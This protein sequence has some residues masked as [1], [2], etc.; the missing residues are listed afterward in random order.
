M[1]KLLEERF[2]RKYRAASSPF[3]NNLNRSA[4]LNGNCTTPSSCETGKKCAWMHHQT[5]EQ[6]SRS[7]KWLKFSGNVEYAWQ[8]VK[9]AS[10]RRAAEVFMETTEQYKVLRPIKR[11]K[12]KFTKVTQSRKKVH[13]MGNIGPTEPRGVEG[14]YQNS[15]CASREKTWVQSTKV[16][17]E[18]CDAISLV[19]LS[20]VLRENLRSFR[21]T[22]HNC[23][24]YYVFKR[25]ELICSYAARVKCKI[26][27]HGGL[28]TWISAKPTDWTLEVN[29]HTSWRMAENFSI[30]RRTSCPTLS[31]VVIDSFFLLYFTYVSDI[32]IA[33]LWKFYYVSSNKT[34]W[35]YEWTS[36]RRL[37]TNPVTGWRTST[38]ETRYRLNCLEERCNR[39]RIHTHF[40]KDRNCEMQE[41]QNYLDSYAR[42]AQ[43]KPYLEQQYLGELITAGRRVSIE[44]CESGNNHRYAIVGIKFGCLKDPWWNKTSQG[45]HGIISCYFALICEVDH[46]IIEKSKSTDTSPFEKI[47][48]CWIAV[49]WTYEKRT[50]A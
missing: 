23:K 3:E 45:R 47:W 18:N 12:K 24:P 43:V 31:R 50:F 37:V 4:G 27:Y 34:K 35:E 5:D 33:G 7:E 16:L 42:D 10:G 40:L 11:A 39:Q 2:E 22:L 29:Y 28:I 20:A 8:L 26:G 13:R 25:M 9:N 44:T 38:R 48:D 49:R 32:V 15:R 46:G 17:N 1:E 6:S 19:F 41:G 14:M 21:S 36:T 30:M